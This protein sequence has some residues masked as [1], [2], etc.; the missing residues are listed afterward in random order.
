M[1]SAAACT[2]RGKIRSICGLG[3]APLNLLHPLGSLNVLGPVWDGV[4]RYMSHIMKTSL[5]QCVWVIDGWVYAL[6]VHVGLACYWTLGECIREVW[7]N[8]QHK[9]VQDKPDFL[10]ER[11]FFL[12]LSVPFSLYIV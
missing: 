7:H 8:T 10:F 12:I 11:F 9:H 3:E 4:S 1:S 6:F 5:R 2:H